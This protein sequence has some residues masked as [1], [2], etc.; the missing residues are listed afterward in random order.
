[1]KSP[2]T[3]HWIEKLT[4]HTPE[5]HTRTF[6]YWLRLHPPALAWCSDSG[7]H[8]VIDE[9]GHLHTADTWTHCSLSPH[10]SPWT[11]DDY[12]RHVLPWGPPPP[13]EG[14][15][16][17]YPGGE[18]WEH[19]RMLWDDRPAL[20]C[21]KQVPEGEYQVEKTVWL[22]LDTGLLLRFEQKEIDPRAG[23]VVVEILQHGFQ[24]DVEPPEGV[25]D[26]PPPGKPL[27]TRDSAEDEQDVT[28]EQPPEERSAIEELIARSDAAWRAGDFRAF[29]GAWHFP[30]GPMARSLPDKAE[31]Q[32]RVAENAGLWDRW[33][34][35]IVSITRTD[36]VAMSTGAR[37][38]S[39]M[40][41]AGT[42]SVKTDLR[43]EWPDGAW[44][45]KAFFYVRK[46]WGR[47]RIVHW[48][49][50]SEELR[51]ARG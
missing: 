1:M 13:A 41:A 25:F 30:R 45:G 7:A 20:R 12:L 14:E 31:W 33:E 26:L 21:W 32:R 6:H 36:Y 37:S 11:D 35:A 10:S 29:A 8:D 40:K 42:L 19:E 23:R 34:S 5:P 27:L 43:V 46:L 51:A 4:A 17:S 47:Y 18:G 38:S 9:R 39:L 3:A 50:P 48:E 16:R 49:F 44:E 22:E 24:Y 28:E 2:Q 15:D